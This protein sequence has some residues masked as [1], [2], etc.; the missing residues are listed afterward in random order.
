MRKRR[1]TPETVA[2]I[3]RRV[4][5]MLKRVCVWDA[6]CILGDEYGCEAET[7]YRMVINRSFKDLDY[8][9]PKARYTCPKCGKSIA[10]HRFYY[11]DK[12]EKQYICK[13]CFIGLTEVRRFKRRDSFDDEQFW[14][15]V[16]GIGV[17]TLGKVFPTQAD[18]D[19]CCGDAAMAKGK[20]GMKP[21]PGK[22]T[23]TRGRLPHGGRTGK[24]I[25][26]VIKGFGSKHMQYG[27]QYEE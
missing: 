22:Y 18:A 19:L 1:M 5:A 7:A 14:C 21:T 17:T 27:K 16:C 3:R 26:P 23:D 20:G 9:P 25:A 13:T 24:Y 10:T 15:P 8:T 12:Q 6:C 4:P 2:A 11:G